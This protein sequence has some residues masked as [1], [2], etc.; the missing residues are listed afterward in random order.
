MPKMNMVP[1]IVRDAI[2][3][4]NSREHQGAGFTLHVGFANGNDMDF[5]VAKWNG[6]WVLKYRNSPDLAM[7]NPDHV[8]LVRVDFG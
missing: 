7:V 4:G 6:D 8:S 3:Y 1:Q 2:E 5:D